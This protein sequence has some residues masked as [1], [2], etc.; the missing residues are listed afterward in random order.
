MHL[1][2]ENK[3][4]WQLRNKK[5]IDPVLEAPTQ[6]GAWRRDYRKQAFPLHSAMQ[7][8]RFEPRIS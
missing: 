2:F 1:N 8:G 7:R 6:G 3:Q 4:R 5:R